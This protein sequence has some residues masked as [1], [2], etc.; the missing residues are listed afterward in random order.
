M[1]Y[2]GEPFRVVSRAARRRDDDNKKMV[3]L[4]RLSLY[5][6]FSRRGWLL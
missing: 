1:M 2:A 4:P 5:T 6:H 3:A